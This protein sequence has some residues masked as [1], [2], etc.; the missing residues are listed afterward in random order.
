M[1]NNM[2]NMQDVVA[3]LVDNLTVEVNITNDGNVLVALRLG[4]NRI[5][6]DTDYITFPGG[7]DSSL[8]YD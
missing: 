2:L 7:H 8:N 4:E 5:S 6:V 1:G 3:Y